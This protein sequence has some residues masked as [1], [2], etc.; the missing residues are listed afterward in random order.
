MDTSLDA[1]IA[2]LP[3]DCLAAELKAGYQ[4]PNE[5]VPLVVRLAAV[6]GPYDDAKAASDAAHAL[7]ARLLD[8]GLHVGGPRQI[9]GASNGP[10]VL[11]HPDRARWYGEVRGVVSEAPITWTV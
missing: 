4:R 7:V 9:V 3:D 8:S 1:V 10:G 11:Q 6:V 2:A 5:E